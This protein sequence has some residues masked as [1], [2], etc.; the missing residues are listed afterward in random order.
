MYVLDVRTEKKRKGTNKNIFCALL[1]VYVIC[2]VLY[3][4]KRN[5]LYNCII[6]NVIRCTIVILNII[7]CTIV[8]VN[9]IRCTVVFRNKEERNINK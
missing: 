9:V 5:T 6:V 7:C 2:F 1:S 3:N 4:Y 8:I